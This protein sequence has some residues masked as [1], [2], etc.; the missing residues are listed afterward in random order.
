M[1]PPSGVFFSWNE[2]TRISF[3]SLFFT[4]EYS[5]FDCQIDW[6]SPTGGWIKYYSILFVKNKPVP[7][8]IGREAWFTLDRSPVHH[9]DTQRQTRHTSINAHTHSY[10]QF[11]VTGRS[12]ST[13]RKATHTQGDHAAPHRKATAGNR[14]WKPLLW[15]DGA[16]HHTSMQPL[17]RVSAGFNKSNLRL[18]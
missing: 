11:Q 2:E 9:R 14:T 17:F 10:A 4:A 16:N 15:G 12:R 7:A 13:W 18:F 6:I 1:S 3:S 5:R 8:V